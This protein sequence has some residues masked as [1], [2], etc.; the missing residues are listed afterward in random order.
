M[1][2]FSERK[3]FTPVSR[4]IQTE[5][6]SDELRNSLWNVLHA[7][8]F[9][10]RSFMQWAGDRTPLI[11]WFSEQIWADYLKKPIDE[12]PELPGSI[13][14]LIR[15][16]FFRVPWYE[17]YNFIEFIVKLCAKG[18]PTLEPTLNYVLER[19]LAGYR[20]VAGIVTD[21]THPQE[22]AALQ[23]ALEDDKFSG[24]TK[25]LQTALEHLSRK[26]NPDYRNSIKESIS[27]VEAMANIIT[28]NPKAT[29]GDAL[30]NLEAKKKIHG[31]LKNGF[32]SLYGY[33]SNAGGI[34]HAMLDEPN[35]MAHDA[36]YFLLSCT[37]F[38]Q[39]LKTLL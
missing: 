27:A 32:S 36:K 10:K 1:L 6:M 28:G 31:A 38:V 2:K 18:Y 25:H 21:I 9:G 3:G 5:G 37:S 23:A 24:V 7:Q 30:K 22:V 29:L 34:R 26:E 14:D 12:R 13:F 19:E 33:T 15:D 39:Y 11:F 8:I 35:I 4:I 20:I 16:Y 17:V